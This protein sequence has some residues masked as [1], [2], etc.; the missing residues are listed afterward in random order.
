MRRGLHSSRV[1]GFFRTREDLPV[2]ADPRE[3]AR[4]YR[5]GRMLLVGTTNLDA[6]RQVVW[7]MGEIAASGGP[8]AIELFRNVIL[9]SAAIPGAFPPVEIPV[10][11]EGQSFTEMHVVCR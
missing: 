7:N 6:Q 4:E 1:L 2:R 8:Q 9:A 10:R 3:I 11:A 5:R